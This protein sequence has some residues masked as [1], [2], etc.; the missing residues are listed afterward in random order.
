M[1]DITCV[2]T[3]RNRDKERVENCLK[4]LRQQS[5]M[6]NIIVVDYGSDKANLRW[7]RK[8]IPDALTRLIVAPYDT[9]FNKSKAINIGIRLSDTPYLLMTDIDCIFSENF[10]EEALN[11]LERNDKSVVLCQKIDLDEDGRVGELHEPS[12]SGSCIGIDRDWLM[13]VHGFDE[14]YTFWGRED[15]DLVDRAVSD[16]YQTV[17]ITDRVKMF[18][19]W[20][21]PAPMHT[22]AMNAAYYNIPNKPLV[23]NE[24]G[25]GV[26]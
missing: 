16:G 19:Q 24:G 1:S 12:A 26:L 22:L 4:T 14:R 17:W 15:N 5:C 21:S 9:V 8:I 18:H 13:K 11:V 25:W 7:E 10:V 2:L 6:P 3:L 20:H 23:R